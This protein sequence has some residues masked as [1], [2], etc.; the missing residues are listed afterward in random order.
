MASERFAQRAKL[1]KS[2]PFR[3]RETALQSFTR[4]AANLPAQIG[5]GLLDY[6]YG[7]IGGVGSELLGKIS[8]AI[9]PQ[10]LR[11]LESVGKEGF[12][13][14]MIDELTKKTVGYSSQEHE[15]PGDILP[16]VAL[17]GAPTALGAARG[18][19][20]GGIPGA[21]TGAGMGLAGTLGAYGA[22]QVAQPIAQYAGSVLRLPKTAQAAADITAP[23]L[24]AKAGVTALNIARR[25]PTALIPDLAK[26]QT[27]ED[28][29]AIKAGERAAVAAAEE[30]GV[31][32]QSAMKRRFLERK[33][34]LESEKI[35]GTQTAKESFAADADNIENQ[36]TKQIEQ[37]RFKSLTDKQNLINQAQSEAQT[38]KTNVQKKIDGLSKYANKNY[39]SVERVIAEL[40]SDKRRIVSPET[41]D[42][43]FNK[44][45][46]KMLSLGADEKQI[47]AISKRLELMLGSA[48]QGK[49][50]IGSLVNMHKGLND[51][52][53]KERPISA[54]RSGLFDVKSHISKLIDAKGR[55]LPSFGKPWEKAQ[56]SYAQMAKTRETGFKEAAQIGKQLVSKAHQEGNVAELKGKEKISDLKMAAKEQKLKLNTQQEKRIQDIQNTTAQEIAKLNLSESD[57]LKKIA[58]NTK[59]KASQINEI[60]KAQLGKV[61]LREQKTIGAKGASAADWASTILTKGVRSSLGYGI[62]SALGLPGWAKALTAFTTETLGAETAQMLRAIKNNKPVWNKYMAAVGDLKKG[63]PGT[64]I[65]LVPVLEKATSKKEE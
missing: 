64:L 23:A 12:T 9:V 46:Q 25:R 14:Q 65:A 21:L 55:E 1:Y 40:S 57:A 41:E 11:D 2:S 4:Q 54:I 18:F 16:Q 59:E 32:E 49:Y 61:K 6:L 34:A 27:L 29:A 3:D 50:D 60:Y 58:A 24:G 36:A 37:T 10:F 20:I 62:G 33:Q 45:M 19:Q 38:L 31:A 26:Q 47:S 8:P 52:I 35:S 17:Y 63:N 22:Q 53:Y 15:K 42:I 44:S 48:E 43:I 56:T 39:K 51:I 13:R 7:T 5:G 28:T 30:T